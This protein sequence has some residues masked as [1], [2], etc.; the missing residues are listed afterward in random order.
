MFVVVIVGGDS[1]VPHSESAGGESGHSYQH[2]FRRRAPVG[3]IVVGVDA[4]DRPCDLR[5]ALLK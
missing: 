3:P 5:E 1:P 2:S 4:R